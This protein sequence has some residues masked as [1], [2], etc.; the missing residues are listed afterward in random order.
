MEPHESQRAANASQPPKRVAHYQIL[1][2]IGAGGMGEV[3]RA[4]DEVLGRDVA[5][6]FLRPERSSDAAGNKR[7]LREARTASSLNHPN[8]CTI[9]EVGETGGTTYIAMEYLRGRT[10]SSIIQGR[11]LS[12]DEAYRYALQIADAL[13]CAHAHGVIHRDL[14]SANI[15]VTREGY[16]KVLDFGLAKKSA[17]PDSETLT[18]AGS[19]VGTIQYMAPETLRGAEAD[20]RVDVWA[21]GIIL[22]EMSTGKLPFRGSSHYEV[23]SAI[24]RDLPAPLPMESPSGL[25]IVITHCRPKILKRATRLLRKLRL[26]S[27]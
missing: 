25:Q 12:A 21:L 5:L 16:V 11:Q 23:S 4:K 19:I 27:K 7:L 13:A 14:K 3:Y 20:A 9:Y 26:R 6:K 10:L 17:E 24:L 18:A 22:Y 2:H 8:I 15:V 1:E